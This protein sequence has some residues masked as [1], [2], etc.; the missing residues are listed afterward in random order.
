MGKTPKI[1]YRPW[2]LFQIDCVAFSLLFLCL[3]HLQKSNL[4]SMS[5]LTFELSNDN[6][7]I[8]SR[9]SKILWQKI[10]RLKKNTCTLFSGDVVRS[11]NEDAHPGG[12][13]NHSRREDH[14]RAPWYWGLEPIYTRCGTLGC[15][16][17]YVS[18][19]HRAGQNQIRHSNSPR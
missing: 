11:Q 2:Y 9:L 14:N 15:R 5:F 19:Q 6:S 4:Y 18:S 3:S 16:E 13:K 10:L 12:Q 1:S 8:G 17:I 7:L